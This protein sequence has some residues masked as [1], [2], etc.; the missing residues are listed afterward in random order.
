[1]RPHG[2]LLLAALALAG[3]SGVKEQV[4]LARKSPD[5][6]AVVK[7][8]PLEVPANLTA[9]PAA[10][11]PPQPGAPRPQEQS[12]VESARLSVFGDVAASGGAQPSSGEAAV[13]EQAGA[14]QVD[15][16]IRRTVD[17]E[18]VETT[19]SNRPV[20]DRLLDW[21]GEGESSASVVDAAK[22]AERLKKN[23]EE[24]KPATAGETP[25]IEQ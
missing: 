18:T 22:E 15:P 16:A 3:C 8:A 2:V 10:L 20:I 14:M 11:P 6:F 5:E 19:V 12:P 25:S 1:M 17:R 9:D 7:R 21:S 23:Q 4:G 13:L 24:G